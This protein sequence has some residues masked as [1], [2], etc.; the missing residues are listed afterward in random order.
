MTPG[1]VVRGLAQA[2]AGASETLEASWR[3]FSLLIAPVTVTEMW[4]GLAVAGALGIALRLAPRVSATQR[5]AAWAAGFVV[6]AALPL[7]PLAMLLGHTPAAG[8]ASAAGDLPQRAWLHLDMRWSTALAALWAA[9]SLLRGIQLGAHTLRLRRLWKQAVPMGL[10]VQVTGLGAGV[11]RLRPVQIFSTT[12]LDRPSVIGFFVPR[13]LVPAWLLER[14]TTGELEQVVL[15]EAEHLRRGDDWSNLLQK[16]CLVLFPLNPGLWWMEQRLCQEREMACDE[17]VVR[18]TRAPRAYAAC[19]ASLAEHGL[20]RRAEAL[21]LGAWG[22]RSELVDRVHRILARG[23]KL[24]PMATSGFAA[25]VCCGLL[26]SSAVL[27]RCPQLVAF[28]PDK[29]L[30][31]VAVAQ[32]AQAPGEQEPRR[33]EDPV[34]LRLRG[35]SARTRE[36]ATLALQPQRPGTAAME[37]LW[38]APVSG[39]ARAVALRAEMARA[40]PDRD[41][42]QYMILTAWAQVEIVHE[43]AQVRSDYDTVT[44]GGDAAGAQPVEQ[45]TMTRLI[46]RIV[47]RTSVQTPAAQLTA[48]SGWLVL[49]L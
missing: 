22:R 19:L 6:V 43:P 37:R 27:A 36:V 49:Q 2:F 34:T 16:L 26:L 33:V 29:P 45:F 46:F 13:I 10:P 24:S 4:Q 47:P 21:S 9:A 44:Y 48:R 25:L 35:A 42:D 11:E 39:P 23:Q 38:N 12:E 17:G 40:Q 1:L 41:A 28:V 18:Q 7:L 5:F 31:V 30:T 14:L 32:P 3:G 15:H 8:A 20:E